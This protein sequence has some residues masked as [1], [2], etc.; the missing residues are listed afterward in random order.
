MK[1]SLTIVAVVS[2]A[3]IAGGFVLL[4]RLKSGQ[5]LG[6]PA[7]R[8]IPEVARPTKDLVRTNG[9]VLPA[10]LDGYRVEDGA[11]TETELA[12][13]PPDT[14]FARKFYQP[15]DQSPP[16]QVNVVLMGHDRTSI[17]QPDFCLTGVGWV[18][19]RKRLTE[20][21]LGDQGAALW[22]QR[23]D[24]T[25]NVP[26]PS[27]QTV[28]VSGVYVFWFVADGLQTAS[29]WERTW[30]T[31]RSLL[32]RNTMP[33]WAYLS[34]FT[35]CPPGREDEAFAQLSGIVGQVA[36]QV[37]TTEPMKTAAAGRQP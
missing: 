33:R 7:V 21:T 17:H 34:F 29:H 5:Q 3:L 2:L 28:A 12:F 23:F 22:V 27:G 10:Q 24:V 6:A 30:W 15:A 14:A 16:M 1:R 25:R 36:P 11:I 19:L 37:L 8:V 35:Q 13:L 20:L 4:S 32:F 26:L 9:V 31:M 18:I